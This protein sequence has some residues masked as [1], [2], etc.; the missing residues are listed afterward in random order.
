MK[1]IAKK[2]KYIPVYLLLALMA[3]KAG[4]QAK[5]GDNKQTTTPGAV[6]ELESSTA[7]YKGLLMAKIPLSSTG[8][9][10]LAGTPVTGMIVYN[11]N[12]AITS[13]DTVNYPVVNGGTGLYTFDGTG[14]KG[15]VYTSTSNAM[16]NGT[17]KVLSR[18]TAHGTNNYSVTIYD[19]RVT[20][21]CII[22]YSFESSYYYTVPTLYRRVP[23]V[24]FTIAGAL[25]PI[26]P[27]MTI[28]YMLIEK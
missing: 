21:D 20:S 13:A 4:A 17:A 8:A 6:L 1:G 11:T 9:W 7:P 28:N 24:S 18:G 19:S 26:T 27:D 12:A 5:I 23:G 10:G 25:S 2:L 22:I 16:G 14:W 3:E 15:L